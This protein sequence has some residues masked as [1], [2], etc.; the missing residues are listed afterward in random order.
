M[1][2]LQQRRGEGLDGQVRADLAIGWTTRYPL[3]GVID[4]RAVD[5]TPFVAP[6]APEQEL[7]GVVQGRIA[8]TGGGIK[9]LDALDGWARFE[10]LRVDVDISEGEIIAYLFDFSGDGAT[11]AHGVLAKE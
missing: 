4:L 5:L 9:Q 7:S 2:C 1:R 10:R 8:L 3:R 11:T 6:L